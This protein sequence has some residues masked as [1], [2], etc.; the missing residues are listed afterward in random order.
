MEIL[1]NKS[2]EKKLKQVNLAVYINVS[3]LVKKE[4]RPKPT[5]DMQT[6]R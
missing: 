2:R 3:L 1:G 5:N 4:G 6:F